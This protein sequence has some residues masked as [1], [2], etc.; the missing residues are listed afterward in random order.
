[1]HV[2][3][4]SHES[5]VKKYILK[6]IQSNVVCNARCDSFVI[7]IDNAAATLRRFKGERK[8]LRSQFIC[9]CV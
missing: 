3:T 2:H 9:D 5:F 8:R 1:M 6:K 4:L 7:Y